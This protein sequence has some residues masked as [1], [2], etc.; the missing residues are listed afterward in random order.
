MNFSDEEKNLSRETI[1]LI[2]LDQVHTLLNKSH[3]VPAC[4]PMWGTWPTYNYALLQQ[5][6]IPT[7][8]TTQMTSKCTRV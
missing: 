8:N 1:T 2:Y 7:I 3:V 5:N 6:M 4:V